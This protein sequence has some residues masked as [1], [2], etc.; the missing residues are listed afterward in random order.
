M[1]LLKEDSSDKRL[2]VNP[3]RKKMK[4]YSGSEKNSSALKPKISKKSIFP[5]R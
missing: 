3:P 1:L 4:K 5:K 2:P